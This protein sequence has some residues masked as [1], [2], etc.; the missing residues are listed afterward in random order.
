MASVG[1]AQSIRPLTRR[2]PPLLVT[3]AALVVLGAYA[4]SDPARLDHDGALALSDYA[5]YAVCH[6]ITDRSFTIAGR[7]MPLCARCTGMYLG[8]SLTFAVLALAG[9][10]RRAGMPSR[11]VLLVLAG[12]MALWAVDGVNSYSHF[13]AHLPHLYPP[14]NWL[15]LVTGMGAG[16][17]IGSFIYPALAQT[18]WRHQDSRPVLASL[19]E[20]AGLVLLA[21]LVVGLV[22]SNQAVILYVLALVS[23]AG[24]VLILA[25]INTVLLLTLSRRDGRAE[26][27]RQA[28]GSLLGGLALALTELGLIAHL[29]FA[30][31]G[32][33]TGLPGL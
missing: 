23:A 31:T 3:L 13:F 14:A 18:L 4:I 8:A 10:P 27:W 29:R 24:V 30:V 19:A 26:R 20:L 2:L 22:L 28:A 33:M 21:L 6:R 9:R 11:R 7:Q 15:R 5:G 16:L 1:P 17:A 12:F 25:A 32:T